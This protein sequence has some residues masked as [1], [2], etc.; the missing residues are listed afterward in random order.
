MRLDFAETVLN[1]FETERVD[2][3]VISS[4]DK[5]HALVQ[6]TAV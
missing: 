1:C 5:Q 4:I 3:K 6:D 2:L